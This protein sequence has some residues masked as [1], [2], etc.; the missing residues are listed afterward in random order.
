[1][2]A[3]ALVSAISLAAVLAACG[4]SGPAAGPRMCESL[5]PEHAGIVRSLRFEV[6]HMGISEGFDL[7]GAN[8]APPEASGCRARD[9]RDPEGREGIDNQLTAVVPAIEGMVG[10]GTLDGLLQ[11]A[12]NSGQLL[13]AITIEGID[14]L[15]NDDCVAV[16]LRPLIGTPLVGTDGRL[17][18]GQTLDIAPEA[19]IS[20]YEGAV[21][22]DG[23][24]ETGPFE[25]ALPV[26]VLD[27]R[28]VIDLRGARIRAR[29]GPD[30]S[31]RGVLA[32]AIANEQIIDIALTL[33]NLTSDLRMQVTTL[34]QLIADL[35]PVDGRCTAFSA[36]FPFEAGAGF[37]NAP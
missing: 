31:L 21:L 30:G 5:A 14:D 15:E 26:S 37:V 2:S 33:G 9:F 27:A 7:D 12:I 23:V 16:S 4:P 34:V 10:E 20:R 3:R 35:E 1:M 8:G 32:G 22:R 11:G 13:M 6:A 17:L 18:D 25:I 29:I 36:S 24:V 28:F 19:Q